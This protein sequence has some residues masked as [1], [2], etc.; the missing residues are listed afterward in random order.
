MPLT[1]AIPSRRE[2]VIAL[3]DQPEKYLYP[4]QFDIRIRAQTVQHFTAGMH[5]QNV[6]DIGC[7][8]AEISLPLLPRAEHLTLLDIS[9]GMLEIANA[10]VP[11]GRARDVTLLGGDFLEFDLPAHSFD[12]I[13]CIGVLAHVEDPA[14]VV[15]GIAKILQPGGMLILEFTDSTHFWGIPVVVYQ[16][17]LRLFR[18]DPYSLNRLNSR[19]V[20]GFCADNNLELMEVFRYGMPPVG[21]HKVLNQKQMYGW[22]CTLYGLPPHSR[23]AWAGNQY[24][25]VLRKRAQ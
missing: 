1:S 12:L 13:F 19:K 4:R 3:F 15:A 24:L 5:F 21:L 22:I 8:S 7:G 2:Q 9:T 17:V 11:Q 14:A 25:C 20:R 18:P 16:H 6:L 23:N 10:R